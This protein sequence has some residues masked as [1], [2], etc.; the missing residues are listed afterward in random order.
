ML[1]LIA[2]LYKFKQINYVRIKFVMIA[3]KLLEQELS[4]KLHLY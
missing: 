2:S 1:D 4:I 3:S